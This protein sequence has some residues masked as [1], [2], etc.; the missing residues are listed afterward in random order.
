M[1]LFLMT[2]VVLFGFFAGGLLYIWGGEGFII[3]HFDVMY[4]KIGSLS[5]LG[6]KCVYPFLVTFARKDNS[7]RINRL[8]GLLENWVTR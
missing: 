6:S 3:A 7:L 2:K 4:T 5:P 1:N 8:V